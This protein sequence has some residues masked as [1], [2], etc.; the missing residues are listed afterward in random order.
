LGFLVWKYSIWQPW[1]LKIKWELCGQGLDVDVPLRFVCLLFELYFYSADFYANYKNRRAYITYSN[2]SV[3]YVSSSY[4]DDNSSLMM[5]FAQ[6]EVNYV[7][8]ILIIGICVK[9]TSDR[10]KF[11]KKIGPNWF[12]ESNPEGSF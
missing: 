9:V 5:L 7:L 6:P 12:I 8:L 11:S 2:V 1:L 4:K 3:F 10:F